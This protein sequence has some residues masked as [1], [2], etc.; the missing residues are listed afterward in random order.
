MLTRSADAAFVLQFNPGQ[1]TVESNGIDQV[2]T[3]DVLVTHDGSAEPSV[4]SGFTFRL[5]DPGSNLRY[6]NAQEAD[7]NF[8]Q[9]PMVSLSQHTGLYSFGAASNDTEY[10]VGSGQTMRLMSV[11][12]LLD[13]SVQS[14]TFD[15]DLT[16][17][18]AKRGTANTGGL[19]DIS[20]FTTVMNGLF[21]VNN[22]VAVPEPSTL[23]WLLIAGATFIHRSRRRR[24]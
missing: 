16:L 14:G 20:S 10:N 23:A 13:R 21:T 3:I 8:S 7:F 5:N 1:T 12:F 9:T 22:A 2:F 17:V 15:L 24:Q 18:D 11:D 19:V 4:F 6:S